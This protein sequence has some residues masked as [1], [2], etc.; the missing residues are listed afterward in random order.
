[1]KQKREEKKKTAANTRHADQFHCA[2]AVGLRVSRCPDDDAQFF[3]ASGMRR[4]WKS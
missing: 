2:R 3:M 4:C 1:M